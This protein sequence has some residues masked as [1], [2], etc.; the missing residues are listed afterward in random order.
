MPILVK[1]D[2]VR[3]QSFAVSSCR[4][5][6]CLDLSA[7]PLK[8]PMEI[9]NGRLSLKKRSIWITAK[10]NSHPSTTH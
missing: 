2:R 6:S 7:E 1:V 5:A 4:N 8:A 3:E 9:V 10:E